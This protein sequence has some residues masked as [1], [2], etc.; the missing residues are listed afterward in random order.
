MTE[1]SRKAR[2]E[3]RIE[4]ASVA[5]GCRH[6]RAAVAS[7]RLRSQGLRVAVLMPRP[8]TRSKYPDLLHRTLVVED[9]LIVLD[10]HGN[11]LERERPV[12]CFD[13]VLQIE[14]LDREM[15]VAIA[16][17]AANRREVSL[18]HRLDHI[19]FPGD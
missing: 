16:E 2:P 18:F 1:P 7:A 9:V 14:I 11:G 19:G 12:S 5:V 10:D 15:V 4:A 8:P 6:G 13:H 17:R 3:P